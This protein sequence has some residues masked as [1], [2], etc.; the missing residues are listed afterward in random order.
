MSESRIMENLSNF[1]KYYPFYRLD[2]KPYLGRIK[3]FVLV[4]QDGNVRLSQLIF[5]F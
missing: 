4:E 5:A 2:L 1:E 3:Q